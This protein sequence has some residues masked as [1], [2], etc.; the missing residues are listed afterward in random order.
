MAENEQHGVETRVGERRPGGRSA[1]VRTSVL[2]AAADL[3]AEVGYDGLST[4][5]VAKRAGVHRTTVYRRWPTK[6]ELVADAV[7]LTAEEQVPIPDTGRLDDDLLALA[8]LVAASIGGADAVRLS[9][10]LVAAAATN[11]PL[12]ELLHRFMGNRMDQSEPIVTRAIERGELPAGT[13]PRVVIEAVVGALWFRVLLTGEAVDP[14][15]PAGASFVRAITDL[16]ANGARNA[17][18]AGTGTGP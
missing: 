15:G 10:S 12:T 2:T 14:A 8:R 17:D 7:G 6:P 1:R 18:G 13:D 3:L 4:D 9:R 5:E 16:V 11:E